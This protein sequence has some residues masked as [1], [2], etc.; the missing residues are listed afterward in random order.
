MGCQ[1]CVDVTFTFDI[2]LNNH[3]TVTNV[4]TSSNTY[5]AQKLGNGG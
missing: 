4:Y 5:L 1:K 3:Y 2:I